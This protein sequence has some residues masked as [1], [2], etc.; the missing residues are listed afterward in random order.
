[1]LERGGHMNSLNVYRL[2][3]AQELSHLSIPAE[4]AGQVF[5]FQGTVEASSQKRHKVRSWNLPWK[6]VM[7]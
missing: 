6:D 7:D 2:F 3:I 5:L 1:M 4:N